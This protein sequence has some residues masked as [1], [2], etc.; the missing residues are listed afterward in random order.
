MTASTR[1]AAPSDVERIRFGRGEA[2]RVRIFDTAETATVVAQVRDTPS[3]L[4]HP[5]WETA[6]SSMLTIGE[7]L[8]RNRHR[9]DYYTQRAQ[10]DNRLLYRRFRLAHDRVA[11]FF[12]HRYGEPVAY[13]EELAVPG[14]HVFDFA[15]AA[16][17]GPGG[18]HVDA[19]HAQTPLLADRSADISGVVN[20]TVPFAVPT[21]GTGMDLQDDL[22]GSAQRGGAAGFASYRPGLMVFTEA[23][24]WHRI[25][26]S[27]TV[28]PG[29]RRVTLQGHGVR[30][31][32]RWIL[33]W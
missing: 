21:G 11:G 9:L 23:D 28:L 25:G 12:E 24:Y 22:P 18:W 1:P 7:P 27:R 3:A 26:S 17:Y 13:A 6:R 8:Y 15:D 31:R 20:F 14:F 5:A 29:E 16:D 32:G 30:L 10:A 4:C 2:F 19:L 33:F